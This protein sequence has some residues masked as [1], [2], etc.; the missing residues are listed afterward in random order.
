MEALP[1]SG[2]ALFAERAIVSFVRHLPLILAVALFEAPLLEKKP[3]LFAYAMV[4]HGTAWMSAWCF[5]LW[6]HVGSGR[7][8]VGGG[9][10]IKEYLGSGFQVNEATAM[11]YSPA[12]TFALAL[13]VTIPMGLA[14]RPLAHGDAVPGALATLALLVVAWLAAVVRGGLGFSR[15]WRIVLPRFREAEMLPP[16]REDHRA[17]RV[18]GEALVSRLPS[19]LR[20]LYRRDLLQLRRRHRFDVAMLVITLAVLGLLHFTT[21]GASDGLLVID[22]VL[23]GLIGGVFANPVF[24]LSG[25]ELEPPGSPAMLVASRVSLAQA[26]ALVALTHQLPLAVGVGALYGL[27][28]GDFL[29]AAFLG[30]GGLLVVVAFGWSYAWLAAV[31]RRGR[32]AL[33]LVFRS[34][35]A[36]LL[37]TAGALGG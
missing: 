28:S 12:A 18:F 17:E 10:R 8:L 20:A 9:N 34:V 30:V 1:A 2:A 11:L 35:F 13:F 24:K 29:G 19:P 16:W 6:L 32:A 37:L 27:A 31:P 5:G 23:L 3:A 26:R 25:S 14:A 33:S 7:S 4:V 15:D 36:A 21:F 22:A